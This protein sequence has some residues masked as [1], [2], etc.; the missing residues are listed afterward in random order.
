[1]Y[2]DDDFTGE[3]VRDA[4]RD[5]GKSC[6]FRSQRRMDMTGMLIQR[7]IWH[8]EVL[9]DEVVAVNAYSD[10][11]PVVGMEPSRGSTT[12]GLFQKR[13]ASTPHDV[14]QDVLLHFR[15]RVVFTP[16]TC[17]KTCCGGKL[18]APNTTRKRVARRVVDQPAKTKTTSVSFYLCFLLS[19]HHA[20]P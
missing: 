13:V 3:V 18:L 2:E 15:L 4:S 9:D 1:M 7:R 19:V 5:P 12:E 14:L 11:S 6:L 16:R 20:T 8:Q 10:S 17:C